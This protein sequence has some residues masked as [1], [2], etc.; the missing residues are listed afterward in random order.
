MS[1]QLYQIL[2]APQPGGSRA[3]EL[4]SKIFVSSCEKSP[5]QANSIIEGHASARPPSL[6]STQ[7]HQILFAQQPGGSPAAISPAAFLHSGAGPA[8]MAAPSAANGRLVNLVAATT[9]GCARLVHLNAVATFDHARLVHPDVTAT[10]DHARLVRLDVATTFGCTRLVHPDVVAPFDH[11]RSAHPDVVATFGHARP[12]Y[13]VAATA[14]GGS[15][16]AARPVV[17]PSLEVRP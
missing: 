10:F 13:S 1:T 11:A 15:G 5:P 14:A 12:I 8:R 2:S 9:S 4:F 6:M 16:V 3:R 7:L 17:A